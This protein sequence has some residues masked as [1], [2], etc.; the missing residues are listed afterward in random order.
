MAY[1]ITNL[2]NDLLAVIP[3]VEK[4][5]T[6]RKSGI[7][8]NGSVQQLELIRNELKQILVYAQSNTLPSKDKRYTAFSR[9]IVD[10][11]DFNF[12][13]GNR[14]CKLADNYKRR[15]K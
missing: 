1:D 5:L 10:E 14:L 12:P 9:Y 15:L 4:E 7:H 13:L 6:D 8:G 2:I 3:D 11:W